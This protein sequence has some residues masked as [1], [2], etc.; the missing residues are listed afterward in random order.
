MEK[1][2]RKDESSIGYEN[3]GRSIWKMGWKLGKGKR[4]AKEFECI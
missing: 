4:A 2:Q 3:D 1:E